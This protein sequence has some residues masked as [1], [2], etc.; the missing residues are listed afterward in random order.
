M[1]LFC[2]EC[3]PPK[4]SKDAAKTVVRQTPHK[5]ESKDIKLIYT[6]GLSK[7][8]DTKGYIGACSS[9]FEHELEWALY[10]PP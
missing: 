1:L 6:D 8:H 9:F 10:D 5:L 4:A 7:W 2:T 3:W